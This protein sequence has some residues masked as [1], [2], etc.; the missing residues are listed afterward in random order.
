MDGVALATD[1]IF[2]GDANFL[3]LFASF[4]ASQL[5]GIPNQCLLKLPPEAISG[6]TP[7]LSPP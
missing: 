5:L 3:N 6:C 2:P 1:G 4:Q 7:F